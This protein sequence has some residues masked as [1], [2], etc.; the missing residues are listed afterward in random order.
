MCKITACS[1]DVI[2]NCDHFISYMMSVPSITT[3]YAYL[4][5]STRTSSI[6][7]LANINLIF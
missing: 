3:L 5:I 7:L 4:K 1:T 6:L 2:L